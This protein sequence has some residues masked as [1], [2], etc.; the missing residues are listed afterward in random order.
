[1][2]GYELTSPYDISTCSYSIIK[3]LISDGKL[4]GSL[5]GDDIA[6]NHKVRL[7]GLDF[8]NDGT[9][10]FLLLMG[11]GCWRDARKERV[12]E[13]NLSTPYDLTDITL[14][15][16]AG[17]NLT[18]SS[19]L[20][21]MGMSF[22]K[23]GKRVFIVDHNKMAIGQISLNV[24]FSTASYTIDGTIVIKRYSHN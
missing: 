6:D 8:N 2:Y 11:D 21:P 20:N 1:M 14:V 10:I 16:N 23:N 22:S 19:F 15:E 5:A 7:Q 13:F 9:K 17:I 18:G 24:A 3:L 12:L 4:N